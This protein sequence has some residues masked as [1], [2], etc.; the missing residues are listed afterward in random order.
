[1]ASNTSV[2]ISATYNGVK[3]ATLTVESP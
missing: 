3:T 1:V 2:T